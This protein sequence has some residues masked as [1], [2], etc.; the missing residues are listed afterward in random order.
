M[1][2]LRQ[3]LL[4]LS[5]QPVLENFLGRNETAKRV[6]RRFFAGDLRSD[7]LRI[8]QD[9]NRDGLMATLDFL[10]ERVTTADLAHRAAREYAEAIEEAATMGL[11]ADLSVKLSHIGLNISEDTVFRHLHDIVERAAAA[12][13]LVTIDMEQAALSTPVLELVYRVR[14]EFGNV[15]ITVQSYLHRSNEDVDHLNNQKVPVRLVRGSYLES[16]RTAY[17]DEEDITLHYMRQIETLMRD[18]VRPVFATHD[19][20]LIDFA[21]DMAFIYHREKSEFELQMLYGIRD[22][23]PRRLAEEG[24]QVRIRVP[25]GE[26]WVP[27]FL[28][29]VAERPALFWRLLRE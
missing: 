3:T 2:L 4:F 5:R 22:G 21:A 18:G 11:Q 26:C 28:R 9:L 1:Q 13:V 6:S 19:E 29:L 12:G 10:G 27:Y 17:Q 23:L 16:S 8:I 7:A 25:Y 15:G 20:K 24:Y 14:K